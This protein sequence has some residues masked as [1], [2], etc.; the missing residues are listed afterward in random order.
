MEQIS[1]HKMLLMLTQLLYRHYNINMY[2]ILHLRLNSVPYSD[3]YN[4]ADQ[5]YGSSYI[6]CN[7]WDFR[8]RKSS[9]DK[10]QFTLAYSS[11]QNY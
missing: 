9:L 11:L 7:T 4:F 8:R 1:Y 2:I 3:M 6:M 10:T 5:L